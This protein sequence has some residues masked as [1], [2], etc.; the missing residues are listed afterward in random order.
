MQKRKVLY[1][2]LAILTLVW[3]C[4]CD[5]TVKAFTED[6]LKWFK[7]YDKTDIIVFVSEKAEQD[8]IVFGKT[9][10][11][12]NSVRNVGQ[13]YYNEN[14]LAVP[15]EFTKGSYHQSAKMSNGKDLYSHEVVT[16]SKSSSGNDMMEI[17]FIGT[18]FNGKHLKSIRK[19]DGCTYYFDSS[20]AN[21][22][23]MNV[24]KG[25]K[26]FTFDTNVG[27]VKY[28]DDRGVIWERSAIH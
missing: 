16:M 25:I 17:E 6:E 1:L 13:G 7:P 5:Y 11:H 23:G 2:S 27:I 8:S 18:I 10:A 28:V 22:S 19:V 9:I 15:Y 21:Y 26:S 14:H 12:S 3:L 4:G 24:E 20:K